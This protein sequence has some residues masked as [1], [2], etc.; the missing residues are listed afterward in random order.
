MSKKNKP[1]II[2]IVQINDAHVPF[3]DEK[4]FS[5]IYK[6]LEYFKPH[7]LVI[8]GDF[9]DFYELSCFDKNPKRKLSLQDE[10]DKSYQILKT[11]KELVNE[12]HFIQ[13]NHEE[14]LRKFL[15]K[16]PEL[17]SLKCL[18]IDKLLNLDLLK[19]NFY[20]HEYVYKSLSF[21]H[22]EVARKY[23]SYTARAEHDNYGSNRSIGHTHRLGSYFKT[24]KR[25]TT[26]CYEGGCTCILNPEYISG[27]P[28]WQ[29]AI[30]IFYFRDNMFFAQQIP[31][32]N[33]QFIF[34][35]RMFK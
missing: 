15:W 35:G 31:I 4:T 8:P 25:G 22:G 28:N 12:I 18:E 10:I 24:D 32:H 34:N 26:S 2:K 30:T 17:S 16:N 6:F 9:V 19:I 5:V 13:G 7:Q 27:T 11:L 20:E 21:T 1:T 23:S 14:R 3:H 29:Q 33:N